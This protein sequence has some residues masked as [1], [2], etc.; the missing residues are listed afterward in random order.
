M[1]KLFTPY[2]T[3]VIRLLCV[4]TFIFT[5][6]NVN[7]NSLVSPPLLSYTT[8]AYGQGTDNYSGAV[9]FNINP[10]SSY[11]YYAYYQINISGIGSY[12]VYSG[13]NAL[14]VPYILPGSYPFT[15]NIACDNYN[16]SCPSESLYGT[17]YIYQAT[18][19]QVEAQP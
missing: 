5:S 4:V 16:S 7:H 15:I 1:K 11:Y 6:C 2:S 12:N 19:T 3:I 9:V 14:F 17:F 13:N 18:T 10:L 8:Y